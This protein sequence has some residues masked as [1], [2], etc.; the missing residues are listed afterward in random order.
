MTS[1]AYSI[2]AQIVEMWSG[3]QPSRM[4]G[5]NI[6]PNSIMQKKKAKL[7]GSILNDSFSLKFTHI[8]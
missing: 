2:M 5:L 1:R 6:V 8:V 7:I 3:I 4:P